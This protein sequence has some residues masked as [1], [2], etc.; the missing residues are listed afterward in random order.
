MTRR[1]MYLE[2]MSKV[3][4]PMNKVILDGAAGRN[5]VPYLPLPELQRNKSE[6]LTMTPPLAGANPSRAS[7]GARP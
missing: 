6:T 2:T 3:L 4:A 7:S 5:V 1:R